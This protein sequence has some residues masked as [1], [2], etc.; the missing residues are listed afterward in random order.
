M[1]EQLLSINKEI[2]QRGLIYDNKG[3]SLPLIIENIQFL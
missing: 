2:G 3:K 1:N